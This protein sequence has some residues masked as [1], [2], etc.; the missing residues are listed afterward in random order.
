MPVLKLHFQEMHM[1]RKQGLAL[2]VAALVLYIIG[3]IGT[4]AGLA[5]IMFMA[6]R[7]LWGLGDG[8]GLGYLFFCVGISLSVLGVVLMRCFR[9][10]GLV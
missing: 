1:A 7:D 10:R 2:G 8:R 6:G 5:L 9:N 3:G 4:F